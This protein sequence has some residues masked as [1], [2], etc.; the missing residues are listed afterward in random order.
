MRTQFW[1]DQTFWATPIAYDALDEFGLDVRVVV[2]FV[3]P[4][5]EAPGN[6]ACAQWKQAMPWDHGYGLIQFSRYWWR[7]LSVEDRRRTLVHEAAH[8]I[9][10]CQRGTSGHDLPWRVI[11]LRLGENPQEFYQGHATRIRMKGT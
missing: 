1:N 3:D 8:I 5:L 4:S 11:M 6:I 10:I 9:D 7:A 2:E